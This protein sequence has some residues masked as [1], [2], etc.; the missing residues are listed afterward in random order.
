MSNIT[1][2]FEHKRQVEMLQSKADVEKY[3]QVL[4]RTIVDFH[5]Y[6]V[7][8]KQRLFESIA[9]FN[10]SLLNNLLKKKYGMESEQN[11]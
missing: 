2:L 11:E 3:E 4:I 8:E 7:Q 1:S 9:L 10:I 6:S 5:T